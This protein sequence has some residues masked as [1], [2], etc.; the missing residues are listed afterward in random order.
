MKL[1][2]VVKGSYSL[3]LHMQCFNENIKSGK[4]RSLKGETNINFHFLCK[5]EEDGLVNEEICPFGVI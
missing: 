3:T 4:L 2:L 1:L 5:L